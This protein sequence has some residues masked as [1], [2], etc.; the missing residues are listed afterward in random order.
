MTGKYY[1]LYCSDCQELVTTII[2]PDSNKPFFH[3]SK[4]GF[5]SR[6]IFDGY[7]PPSV[8]CLECSVKRA[9]TKKER[10]K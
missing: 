9:Q 4:D 8:L 5:A 2:L 7:S 3:L 10:E 1:K 6:F